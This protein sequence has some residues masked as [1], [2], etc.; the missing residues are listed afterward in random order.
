VKGEYA[1]RNGAEPVSGEYACRAIW[2]GRLEPDGDDFL[3]VHLYTEIREW[4][5]KEKSGPRE[6]PVAPGTPAGTRPLFRM[7]YV[8]KD[9][10]EVVF[11]FELEGIPVSHRTSSLTIPLEL[12]SS[13]VS[14]A[15]LSRRSYDDFVFRGSNRV[16]VPASGFVRR[17]FQ[18][19]Y[20]WKW[21]RER[22]LS[23]GSRT[24][25]FIQSHAAEAVVG[26]AAH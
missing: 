19:E 22:K 14:G 26:L 11:D 3:L 23:A 1:L 13:A 7:N 15:G 16:A 10:E 6:G 9:G 8:L 5:L 2:E 21:R 17:M 12:P 24:I 4:S 25:L 18:R 20:A